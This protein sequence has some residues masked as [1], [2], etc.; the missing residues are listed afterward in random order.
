METTY[1]AQIRYKTMVR[2]LSDPTIIFFFFHFHRCSTCVGS[3]YFT[4]NC[5]FIPRD[6][7]LIIKCHHA[8]VYEKKKSWISFACVIIRIVGGFTSS[9]LIKFLLLKLQPYRASGHSF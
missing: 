5:Y 2:R 7:L 8:R 3:T 6:L 4:V 1:V 9:F